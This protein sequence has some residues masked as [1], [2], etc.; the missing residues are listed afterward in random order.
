MAD[1][2]TQLMRWDDLFADLDAQAAALETAE[3]AAEV[4]ERMRAEVGAL[5]MI[6]RLRPAVGAALTVQ[7]SGGRTVAGVLTRAGVDW[8]LVDVPPAREC[9][10][11]LAA[12]QTV[13]G[14]GRA[15]SVP[16]SGG[17]VFARLTLRSAL[18]GLARDRAGVRLYLRDGMV[19]DATIDRVG[20]DF[21]EVARHPAGE[22]R[23]REQVRDVVL[24]N[25]DRVAAVDR[26]AP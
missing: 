21:L 18:R 26:V 19:L 9:L 6:D 24:V 8:L 10:V 12:V 11:A 7:L 25:L 3:R 14:L 5:T 17:A 20:K 4:V 2:Y 1:G 22:A 16:G 23:R 13:A 15:A